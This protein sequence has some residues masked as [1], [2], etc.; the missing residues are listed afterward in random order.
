MLTQEELHA[1]KVRILS[2]RE[3]SEL[4]E[5]DD[6]SA[7]LNRTI[8]IFEKG[9]TYRPS[10]RDGS[11]GGLLDFCAGSSGLQNNIPVIIVPDL[12]ARPD[13]LINLIC[14]KI[15]GQFV[16]D[17]LNE[18]N[19]IVVCVGDGVHSESPDADQMR[20]MS[21]FDS[22]KNRQ[23]DNPSMRQEMHLT[24][25]TMMTVM[26]LK[27]AFPKYFHFLKG[28]HENVLNYEG[29]G[30]HSF[31][32]YAMEGEMVKDFV[33]D[34]YNDAVL[35]L[36]HCFEYL[37]PI[38][39]VFDKFCISHAEP[40]SFYSRDDIINYHDETIQN[41]VVLNF[42]WT[43]NDEATEGSVEE[44]YSHLTGSNGQKALW[45]GGHR[46][47]DGKYLFRQNGHYIQIHN[48]MEMN[49]VY[50]RPDIDFNPSTDIISIEKK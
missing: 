40:C 12:H 21:S 22:W 28:N 38:V 41:D 49:V 10:A 23:F 3:N 48:P 14:C 34:Y 42:T 30:D 39:A 36:I 17:A 33:S 15:K 45:F 20:W 31:R 27:C 6:L 13:F 29:L 4:P 43:G 37:L 16:L 11:A 1:L 26:E 5:A 24:L 35:H 32:K 8:S 46:P 44:L 2:F 50:V 19:L 18:G 9:G 47:I 7:L 25:A